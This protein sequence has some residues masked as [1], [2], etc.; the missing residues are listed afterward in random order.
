MRGRG[1]QVVEDTDS[2]RK[3]LWSSCNAASVLLSRFEGLHPPDNRFENEKQ[4]PANR[5][6]P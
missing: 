6:S 2:Q 5:S 4:C 1:N 3:M